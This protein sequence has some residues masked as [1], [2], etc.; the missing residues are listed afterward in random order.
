MSAFVWTFFV[1]CLIECGFLV[2][3]IGDDSYPRER[4]KG[5]DCISLFTQIGFVL[6]T[7]YLLFCGVP[8]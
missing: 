1:L 7:A 4:T 5:D 3:K 8:S 6:W 2:G